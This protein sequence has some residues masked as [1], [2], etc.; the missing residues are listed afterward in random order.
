LVIY[1]K[2]ANYGSKMNL[3]HF[4]SV[5]CP[6]ESS[7]LYQAKLLALHFIST[8]FHYMPFAIAL[9]MNCGKAFSFDQSK[10]EIG[11]T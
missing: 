2:S 5:V 9:G 6:C 1:I 11:F 3:A 8:Y 7:N 4:V 10:M